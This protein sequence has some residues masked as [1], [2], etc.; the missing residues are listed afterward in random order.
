ML[1]VRSKELMQH[2]LG[3]VCRI[4]ERMGLVNEIEKFPKYFIT[5][6]ALH[7]RADKNVS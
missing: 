6:K 5:E 2:R 4:S 1:V 3:S 7:L